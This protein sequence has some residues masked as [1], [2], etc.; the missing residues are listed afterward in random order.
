ML[1]LFRT[2]GAN[3]KRNKEYQF[4]RQDNYPEELETNNFK[5]QKLDYIHHN[6]VQA[7]I[8]DEPE[9]YCWL[10]AR[11]YAGMTGLVEIEI[12]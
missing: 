11:D 2:V 7:G 10:S 9:H 3:N 5:D 6:P 1:W 4:W 12:L 8:V